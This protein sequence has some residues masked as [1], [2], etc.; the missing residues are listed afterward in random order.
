MAKRKSTI[1]RAEL[2]A[3]KTTDARR[4]AE[5]LAV[6][7]RQKKQTQREE[8]IEEARRTKDEWYSMWLSKI[9][10]AA[11]SGE[12]TVSIGVGPSDAEWLR[13]RAEVGLE[14]LLEDGYRAATEVRRV[15]HYDEDLGTDTIFVHVSW[16]PKRR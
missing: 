10:T 5:V 9:D 3:R 6:K 12:T 11:E 16:G 2:T 7:E 4:K 13:A 15:K 1:K 14:F 8:N